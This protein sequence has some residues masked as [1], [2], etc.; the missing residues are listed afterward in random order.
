MR[1][2]RPPPLRGGFH[3]AE[4]HV[5]PRNGGRHHGK[6]VDGANE[7]AAPAHAQ[8]L[9]K[10]EGQRQGLDSPSEGGHQGHWRYAQE[11]PFIDELRPGFASAAPESRVKETSAP[12]F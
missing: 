7:E 4:G 3:G 6:Q 11:R 2:F 12:M 1:P 9:G 8:A 10:G 5:E